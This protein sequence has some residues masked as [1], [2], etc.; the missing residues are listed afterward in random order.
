MQHYCAQHVAH[1]WLPCGNLLQ[2]LAIC[3]MV[4]SQVWKWQILVAA[5]FDGERCCTFLS[6]SLTT[7]SD[8]VARCCIEMLHMFD[9]AFMSRENNVYLN[10]GLVKFGLN[11]LSQTLLLFISISA[12][13]TQMLP[14]NKGCPKINTTFKSRNINEH[15]PT[16]E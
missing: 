11:A 9:W 6:S 2:H 1:V 4:L 8:S 13:L 16:L 15:P 5:V 14:F 12:T 10:I 7:Q 3:W